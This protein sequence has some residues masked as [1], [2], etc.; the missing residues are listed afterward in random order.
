MWLALGTFLFLEL[1]QA[2]TMDARIALCNKPGAVCP[3]V[4]HTMSNRMV[5]LAPTI[6]Q[7][8][9]SKATPSDSFILGPSGF[10]YAYPALMDAIDQAVFANATVHAARQLGMSG[11]VHWDFVGDFLGKPFTREGAGS[12]AFLEEAA[13][14]WGVEGGGL[15]LLGGPSAVGPSAHIPPRVK[16]DL[17]VV[18]PPDWLPGDWQ[19]QLPAANLSVSLLALPRGTITYVYKIWDVSFAAVEELGVALQGTHVK[20]VDYRTMPGLVRAK[21]AAEQRV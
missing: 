19:R 5:D 2:Y 9:Y 14:A 4:A 12:L 3:P 11:H 16:P 21:A 15:A 13:K 10:G 20:L 6:L 1:P 17:T 8:W 18:K 7:W